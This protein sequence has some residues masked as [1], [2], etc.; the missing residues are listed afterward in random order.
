LETTLE[1]L[2]FSL[3]RPGF[4]ISNVTEPIREDL[5][6][7]LIHFSLYLGREIQEHIQNILFLV[8]ANRLIR[9]II[10]RKP[11]SNFVSIHDEFSRVHSL[12]GLLRR[13][14]G[15]LTD[16][17]CLNQGKAFLQKL[18]ETVQVVENLLTIKGV[19]SFTRS[20]LFQLW[21][22]CTT[23]PDF[24]PCL[25]LVARL[26]TL[27][28]RQLFDRID[29]LIQSTQT[30]SSSQTPTL[31]P[32][33][34]SLTI[35]DPPVY[36]TPNDH[37]S[38]LSGQ[39]VSQPSS[40]PLYSEPTVVSDD[41]P[42]RS[43][44]PSTPPS[45]SNQVVDQ[46]H[47]PLPSSSS[48]IPQQAPPQIH[49]RK[50]RQPVHRRKQLLPRTTIQPLLRQILESPIIQHQSADSST[51][52]ITN[53]QRSGITI[54]EA[55]SRRPLPPTP[56]IHQLELIAVNIRSLQHTLTKLVNELLKDQN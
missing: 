23:N 47:P 48:N 40:Q 7:F 53:Q 18:P 35:I 6:L 16:C 56:R 20:L 37:Q 49:L 43:I 44:S 14:S 19:S 32:I 1:D 11:E 55:R 29:R 8:E 34:H 12:H 41:H 26:E 3:S 42:S 13:L 31:F 21:T 50:Q 10:R 27:K 28:L 17:I 2:V 9:F 45:S 38:I 51:S 54:Q 24:P 22:V 30:S 46:D 4:S 15:D 36:S 25:S 5:K 33:F 52:G 39:Q